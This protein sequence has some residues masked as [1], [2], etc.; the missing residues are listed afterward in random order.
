MSILAK[1]YDITDAGKQSDNINE[2]FDDIYSQLRVSI[3]GSALG[4]AGS[5]IRSTGSAAQWSTLLLPNA[6]TIGDIPYASATN[7]LAMLADVAVGKVLVSGGIG[8]APLW[9]QVDLTTMVTGVLPIANG[10]TGLSSFTQGDMLYFTSGVTLSKLAKDTNATRYISNTGSSNAPAWAQV[11]LATGVTGLLPYAN[12][13][14]A[15]AASILV[16]RGSAAGG[17]ALQEI[18]LGSGL[19][20]TNQVLSAAGSGGT[21]DVLT[22]G[23]SADPE[24]IFDSFGYVVMI[25]T[26]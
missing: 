20:M 17:G 21:W 18:T 25:F 11:D 5:F 12:M 7:S 9:G 2:L 26:P 22:N 1:K 19:T 15:T 23:D 24:L 3:L 14:N 6:A 10:G 16:G 4:A 8:V 13:V